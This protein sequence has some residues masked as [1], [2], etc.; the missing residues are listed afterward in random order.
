MESTA[1]AAHVLCST[2]SSNANRLFA[3]RR[4]MRHTQFYTIC[5]PSK[6]INTSGFT[7]SHQLHSLHSKLDSLLIKHRLSSTKGTM[8]AIFTLSLILVNIYYK[9]LISPSG[10]RRTGNVTKTTLHYTLLYVS[11]FLI[12]LN[13]FLFS[14]W[15]RKL[16]MTY[17]NLRV[18]KLSL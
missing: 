10:F 16:R 12:K 3:A 8:L 17:R 13:D 18:S 1:I 9:I 11:L 4:G 14:A 5:S 2:S 7:T 15:Y 6:L